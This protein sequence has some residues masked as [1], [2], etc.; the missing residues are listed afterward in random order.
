MWYDITMLSDIYEPFAIAHALGATLYAPKNSIVYV[1]KA[2][3]P[4]ET[5]FLGFYSSYELGLEALYV[6]AI[7]GLELLD[8]LAPWVIQIRDLKLDG[9]IS[10]KEYTKLE[11]KAKQDWLKLKSKLEVIGSFYSSDRGDGRYEDA[12]AI[13]K[14]LIE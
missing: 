6:E 5:E 11:D 9:M 7:E 8:T 10:L 1:A 3:A 4:G 2:C 14:R 13:V 12:W